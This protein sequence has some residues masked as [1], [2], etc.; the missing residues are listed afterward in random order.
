MYSIWKAA[1]RTPYRSKKKWSMSMALF[2][3]A[4]QQN[5][6]MNIFIIRLRNTL[7]QVWSWFQGT[8]S[9]SI[10]HLKVTE[11]TVSAEG[12]LYYRCWFCTC[13]KKQTQVQSIKRFPWWL[14]GQESAYNVG[15]TGD[16][17][18]QA[19]LDEGV[20]THS[21]FLPGESPW[22]KEPSWL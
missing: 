8:Y 13:L 10:H 9:T 4:Q 21:V 16:L 7:L 6:Q 15:D 17:S 14:S 11:M 12:P 3:N 2:Q 20:A 19:P 18:W 5:S 22:T 1:I